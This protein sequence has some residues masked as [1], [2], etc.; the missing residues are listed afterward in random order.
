MAPA[1][2]VGLMTG[3]D[4]VHADA[5]HRG[6]QVRGAAQSGATIQEIASEQ[7]RRYCAAHFVST[8]RGATLISR[9][10]GSDCT[11]NCRSSS[12]IRT[13]HTCSRRGRGGVSSSDC[14]GNCR[15]RTAIRRTRTCVRRRCARASCMGCRRSLHHTSRNCSNG[16]CSW[17]SF[18]GCTQRL[19]R[20]SP[21]LVVRPLPQGGEA[22]VE[23][24]SI[25][26]SHQPTPDG[27]AC[28]G[29]RPGHPVLPQR[30]GHRVRWCR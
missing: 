20:L 18:A 7:I 13:R 19:K 2:G 5:S 3:L 27:S 4:V 15:R 8:N 9:G 26:W 29:S 11:D 28:R 25:A 24:R 12:S 23:L 10:S 22:T 6:P 16:T 21:A 30:R 17:V 1:A 14:R